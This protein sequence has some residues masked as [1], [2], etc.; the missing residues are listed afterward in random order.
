MLSVYKSS[1][2]N[3]VYIGFYHNMYSMSQLLQIPLGME[4]FREANK[5]IE[6]LYLTSTSEYGTVTVLKDNNDSLFLDEFD[7]II[8]NMCL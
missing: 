7:F 1:Y 4:W 5:Y 2:H 6:N 3:N 8:K